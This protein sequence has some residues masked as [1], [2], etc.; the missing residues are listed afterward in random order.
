MT[1]RGRRA[2]V[3][4]EATGTY[5][6]DASMALHTHAR[7]TVMVANPRATANFAQAMMKRAKTDD[8]DA[9]TILAFLER[10]PFVEWKPPSQAVLG[11]RAIG[12]QLKQV[13]HQLTLEKNRLHAAKHNGAIPAFL[14]EDIEE[15]IRLLT[16]RVTW[17]QQKA[18]AFIAEYD[19]LSEKFALLESIPGINERS[20]IYL[21]GELLMLP[22]DM[23]VRQWVAY[24]GLDPRPYRSGTS[25]NKQPRIS[26]VG[27]VFIR[28][29]LYMPA[30]TAIRDNEAVQAFYQRLI[31]RGKLKMK[32]V[33]A[34]MRKLL[35]A[36]YGMFKTNTA[37]QAERCFPIVKPAENT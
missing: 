29:S 21:L 11:L 17:L 6:F 28:R 34:V 27:N 3:C 14:V 33:V 5:S 37:F 16:E 10:M 4:I 7:I 19:E 22:D 8:V 1:K 20:G 30:R 26:K 18:M 25:V 24:A 31:G 15:S 32:G 12:R 2:R 35:H 36:I 13:V 9:Q 23:D